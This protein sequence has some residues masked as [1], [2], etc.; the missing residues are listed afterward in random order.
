MGSEM[1]IRDSDIMTEAEKIG[2]E[3][4]DFAKPEEVIAMELCR[5]TGLL[6]GE[7]CRAEGNVYVE[8]VPHDLIPRKFCKSH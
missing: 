5:K 7:A 8:Q 1:C 3:F 2:Y 6:A 4:T